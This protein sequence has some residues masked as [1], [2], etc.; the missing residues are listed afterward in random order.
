MA[1]ASILVVYGVPP[2]TVLRDRS[3]KVLGSFALTASNRAS[4]EVA[5]RE[6]LG[7]FVKNDV[8]IA[9]ADYQFVRNVKDLQTAIASKP[10]SHVVYYGHAM[11]DQGVLLLSHGNKV[12][13][14]QLV[15][16]LTGTK[17]K[18]FDI[19]GCASVSIAARLAIA[20]PKLTV[21]NLRDKR[22]DNFDVELRTMKV[23]RMSIE[24]QAI[25][26]FGPK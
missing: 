15:S 1:A 5:L 24:P 3:G 10:Y 13:V 9:G 25:H 6:A 17:V 2:S 16:L 11:T 12:S 14:D 23:Q 22:W 26:H 7:A 20:M 21:G 4:F 18:H 8:D 19:L